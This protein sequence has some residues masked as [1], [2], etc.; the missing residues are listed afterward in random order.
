MFVCIR[1]VVLTYIIP[2]HHGVP[3]SK[4]GRIQFK[5]GG[6][7]HA[8]GNRHQRVHDLLL[9]SSQTTS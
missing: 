5:D 1:M 9:W 4:R 7:I 8:V 6:D 3:P 2:G